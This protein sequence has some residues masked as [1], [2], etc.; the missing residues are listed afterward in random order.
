[1]DDIAEN[2]SIMCVYLTLLKM[3]YDIYLCHMVIQ[4]D[5]SAVLYGGHIPWD[6]L[7]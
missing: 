4:K 1:M 5:I 3:H 6:K 2:F 7:L